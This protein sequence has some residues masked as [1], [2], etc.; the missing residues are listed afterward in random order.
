VEDGYMQLKWYFMEVLMNKFIKLLCL[1][2]SLIGSASLAMAP[3]PRHAEHS[4]LLKTT[5]L[6]EAQ[7]AESK[8]KEHIR[9]AFIV[10]LNDMYKTAIGEN[11]KFHE[12]RDLSKEAKASLE[13]TLKKEIE[14]LFDQISAQSCLMQSLIGATS[15]NQIMGHFNIT[16]AQ[17]LIHIFNCVDISEAESEFYALQHSK[18]ATNARVQAANK[19]IAIY[20]ASREKTI[21]EDENI[22]NSENKGTS[23]E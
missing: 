12:I 22:G 5:L 23:N 8:R 3:Q 2:V 15:F 7:K 21:I 14:Q 17:H 1:N 9:R 20:Y 10:C 19:I 18:N 6:S 16:A 4:S 13:A 11:L